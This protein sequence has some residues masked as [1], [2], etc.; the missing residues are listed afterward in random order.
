MMAKIIDLTL[1]ASPPAPLHPKVERG[2][3]EL[4]IHLKKQTEQMPFSFLEE[5]GWG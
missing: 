2:A 3:R 5:K 4:T 1:L